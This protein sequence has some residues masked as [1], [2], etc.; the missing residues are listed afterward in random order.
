PVYDVV[1]TRVDFFDMGL[2]LARGGIDAFLSGEPFPSL[3]EDQ[4]YGTILAYPYYDDSIGTINA[5]M[6]VTRSTITN[7]PGEV[8]QLVRAHVL[9]TR[10]LTAHT[11]EWLT[12]ASRFGIPLHVLEKAQGNMELSWDIDEA[13][14]EKTQSLGERMM[15]MGLIDRHPDYA[16]LFDLSFVQRVHTELLKKGARE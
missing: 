7:R 1:L 12:D 9:A 10:Y 5:G 11:H 8:Y 4:G 13:F 15:E 16:A 3:A 2:A 6:I 14:V